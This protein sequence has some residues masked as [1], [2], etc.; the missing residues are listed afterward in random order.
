[1]D[2]CQLNI[3]WYFTFWWPPQ[4]LATVHMQWVVSVGYQSAVYLSCQ[5]VYT[6]TRVFSLEEAVKLWERSPIGVDEPVK[7]TS[8][9]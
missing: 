3:W 4:I 2:L 8:V 9:W 7:F 6:H 5:C 1:M